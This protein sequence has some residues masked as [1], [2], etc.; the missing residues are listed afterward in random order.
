MQKRAARDGLS[1]QTVS[2]P[3][4]EKAR[5]SSPPHLTEN[6]QPPA[7]LSLHCQAKSA[8]PSRTLLHPSLPNS[9]IALRIRVGRNM[10]K[11]PENTV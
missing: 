11:T 6:P 3:M 10:G 8:D 4:D 9:S 2:G 5:S 7:S 1:V